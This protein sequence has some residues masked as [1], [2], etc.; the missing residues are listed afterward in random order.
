MRAVAE[1][2]LDADSDAFNTHIDQCLGC[3]ACEP[4]C[5]SGVEYGFLVERARAVGT[6]ARGQRL[7][8]RLLL[9]VFGNRALSALAGLGGRLLRIAGL[10]GALARAL[11][12]SFGGARL[13]LAMLAATRPASHRR[14]TVTSPVTAIPRPR[15][16]MLRGCVQHAL[17]SHVNDDTRTVLEAAGC[18]IVDVPGQVCCGALH[19]HS[20]ELDHAHRL[21]RA[22]I[23][24]FLAVD[25]DIIVVNAAG[26]GA[27]MKEYGEQ[28][29]HDDAY[30]IK[31]AALSARVRDV[32]E[33][34]MELDFQPGGAVHATVTYDAPCHLLH[35]QR[36]VSAPIDLL[37]RVPGLEVVPLARADECCGGAGTYGIAHPEI[38]GRILDDKLDAV[39]LSGART[40]CT[41]NP[42][43]IM[44]IGGGLI[45]AGDDVDVRHPVEILARSVRARPGTGTQ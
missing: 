6:D 12:A 11:P 16:A 34:L 8:T 25:P 33:Y 40:V 30:A 35:A 13:G 5:P 27:M 23:D 10:A 38:G 20:G 42:G 44:Q 17:F 37:K 41:P 45:L 28:L 2:R 18:K 36:I 21:A 19:A 29:E 1:G 39:R 14:P 7:T 3:R 32:S 24:A 43:C 22:N 26:C 31:A 15:V 9:G 4:V